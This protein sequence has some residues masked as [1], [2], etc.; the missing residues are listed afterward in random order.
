MGYE[1]RLILLEKYPNSHKAIGGEYPYASTVGTLDLCKV[2]SEICNG[3][4]SAERFTTI[5]RTLV[6]LSNFQPISLG[7]DV[8]PYC[9]CTNNGND[10]RVA[11]FI[12]FDT[13]PNNCIITPFAVM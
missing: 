10:K 7:N 11:V 1:V 13:S 2:G 9:C 12:P 5:P 4:E 3:I 6:P 8:V